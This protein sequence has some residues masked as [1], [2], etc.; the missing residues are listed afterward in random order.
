MAKAL[1]CAGFTTATGGPPLGLEFRM[2]ADG[3]HIRVGIEPARELGDEHG[4]GR[5]PAF[6][7]RVMGDLE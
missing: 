3:L 4:E 7:A 2:A 1:T 5:E 6:A